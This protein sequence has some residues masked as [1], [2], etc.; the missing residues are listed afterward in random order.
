VLLILE[1]ILI[2]AASYL[3]GSIT[4]GDVVARIKKVNLR[5]Q[6][7]GNVGATN[8]YR[9]MGYTPGLIVLT[10]DTLK[11][12]IAVML[13]NIIGKVHGFDINILTGVLAI[14]GHNW[15]IFAKFKGGKGI[16]VTLGVAIAMTPICLTVLGPIWVALFLCFGYVSLA[17]LITAFCYPWVVYLFFQNDDIYKVIFAIVVAIMAIYRH[18]T[19]IARLI[20]GEEHKILYQKKK[21]PN[22]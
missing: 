14:V 22:S 20:K 17:S 9:T 8:V 5:G 19:N 11:G 3:I 16:S 10:C 21:E 13:G 4:T 6:G 7:S 15:P 18:R 1:I 2:S 12:V